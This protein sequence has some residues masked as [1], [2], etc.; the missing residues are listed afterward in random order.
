MLLVSF[1]FSNASYAQVGV[2]PQQCLEK[3]RA[4]TEEYPNACQFWMSNDPAA[5][6]LETT[7][8]DP[9]NG[10]PPITSSNSSVT[11]N[12]W[13]PFISGSVLNVKFA[14]DPLNPN[15]PRSLNVLCSWSENGAK[16][17]TLMDCRSAISFAFGF[18]GETCEVNPY[19]G[20][21][22]GSCALSVQE[23]GRLPGCTATDNGEYSAQH[24]C[25]T[26]IGNAI[27]N[28]AC[29]ARFQQ[30][31]ESMNLEGCE[32]RKELPKP[33][34]EMQQN[35]CK[36]F[37]D[38]TKDSLY[39]DYGRRVLCKGEMGVGNE[40]VSDNNYARAQTVLIRMCN[41]YEQVRKP[42]SPDIVDC[43]CQDEFT[44]TMAELWGSNS[45]T[46]DSACSAIVES[47]CRSSECW[48]SFKNDSVSAVLR[49]VL[50]GSGNASDVAQLLRGQQTA[51]GVSCERYVGP[52]STACKGPAGSCVTAGRIISPGS[53]TL[54]MCH[55]PEPVQIEYEDKQ[56]II[57]AKPLGR[58]ARKKTDVINPYLKMPEQAY[59]TAQCYGY[60]KEL[61]KESASLE[62]EFR[63]IMAEFKNCSRV[64]QI[65]NQSV[66]SCSIAR[67]SALMQLN[68]SLQ[69]L[70]GVDPDFCRRRHCQKS[71]DFAKCM[72]NLP[73][74][75]GV[76]FECVEDAIIYGSGCAGLVEHSTDYLDDT[77]AMGCPLSMRITAGDTPSLARNKITQCVDNV[78]RLN[79]HL[80][81]V[82]TV[83][84]REPISDDEYAVKYCQLIGLSE[85]IAESRSDEKYDLFKMS[86][87]KDRAALGG[88]SIYRYQC[89]AAQKKSRVEPLTSNGKTVL[90]ERI[91]E[92]EPSSATFESSLY[93]TPA[94]EANLEYALANMPPYPDMDMNRL[95]QEEG[96]ICRPIMEDMAEKPETRYNP[97]KEQNQN[98]TTLN[99]LGEKFSGDHS[100]GFSP[101][102]LED[103]KRGYT[104]GSDIIPQCFQCSGGAANKD[105][106]TL[107]QLMHWNRLP[108]KNCINCIKTCKLPNNR[109]CTCTASVQ[110]PDYQGQAGGNQPMQNYEGSSNQ[111][112]FIDKIETR[113]C[114]ISQEKCC[115]DGYVESCSGQVCSTEYMPT[116][117]QPV[118]NCCT[119]TGE[120]NCVE[121]VNHPWPS[122][123]ERCRW[124]KSDQDRFAAAPF[125]NTCPSSSP[126]ACCGDYL[127][128][129]IVP[130]N[131]LKLRAK[132]DSWGKEEYNFPQGQMSR[133][134]IN[135]NEGGSSRPPEGGPIN[136]ERNPDEDMK[137]ISPVP[138]GFY[139]E[140][141]FGYGGALFRGGLLNRQAPLYDHKVKPYMIWWDEGLP[142]CKGWND[143]IVGIGDENRNCGYGGW[144]EL[145]LYQ[146]R[147]L[148]EF[149]TN[150]M[151]NYERT[152]K[153]GSAE[154]YVHAASGTYVSPTS[155]T[156]VGSTPTAKANSQI[157]PIGWRG[158]VSEPDPEY[159]F[160]AFG[161]VEAYGAGN[162][163]AALRGNAAKY[164]NPEL[165]GI[166]RNMDG[167]K[168][169]VETGALRQGLE[170]AKE[171]D[172]LIW[173]RDVLWGSDCNKQTMTCSSFVKLAGKEPL[174]TPEARLPHVAHV[175]AAYTPASVLAHCEARKLLCKTAI[176]VGGNNRRIGDIQDN[177][178]FRGNRSPAANQDP[179]TFREQDLAECQ[180][181]N[182]FDFKTGNCSAYQPY[183][184]SLKSPEKWYV[185][186]SEKNY[187]K[188]PDI[189]GNTDKW[190]IVTSRTLIHP[191]ISADKLGLPKDIAKSE[192]SCS[193]PQIARC[194]EE[195]WDKVKVYNPRL[196]WRV[197]NTIRACREVANFSDD[198]ARL[199]A[200]RN[201]IFDAIYAGCDPIPALRQLGGSP[202]PVS[203]RNFGKATVDRT[204]E[205]TEP[206]TNDGP[207]KLAIMEFLSSDIIPPILEETRRPEDI[208]LPPE[209]ADGSII[210]T[211]LGLIPEISI[212]TRRGGDGS[213]GGGNGSGT[214]DND[215]DG[216]GSGGG[217]GSG[218]DGGG[219][220]NSNDNGL[221]G[222]NKSGWPACEMPQNLYVSNCSGCYV[223]T[224]RCGISGSGVFATRCTSTISTTKKAPSEFAAGD[225]YA[226]VKSQN[227]EDICVRGAGILAQPAMNS[228]SICSGGKCICLE[229]CQTTQRAVSA[230][231]ASGAKTDMKKFMSEI[232]QCVTRVPLTNDTEDKVYNWTDLK[233]GKFPSELKAPPSDF[234]DKNPKL[235]LPKCANPVPN[236]CL[237]PAIC[238][239]SIANENQQ[240]DFTGERTPCKTSLQ[241]DNGYDHDFVADFLYHYTNFCKVGA[242]KSDPAMC[243][244][245][246]NTPTIEWLFKP[247]I[248]NKLKDAD[249]K[250]MQGVS[251]MIFYKL[252]KTEYAAEE[253]SWQN[254]TIDELKQKM[255]LFKDI[256]AK[257]DVTK[258]PSAILPAP[259]IAIII[260]DRY[261]RGQSAIVYDYHQD[262]NCVDLISSNWLENSSCAAKTQQFD[263]HNC[264]QAIPTFKKGCIEYCVPLSRISFMFNPEAP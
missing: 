105:L 52:K 182:G 178:F 40:G 48:N 118:D 226:C 177:P 16:H 242:L 165:Y 263:A 191:S 65:N 172:I 82:R 31:L 100:D 260:S 92:P 120:G 26:N 51:G 3:G 62:K 76:N 46:I 68:S 12:C 27:S 25:R 72:E 88:G 49:P 59:R 28:S 84:K 135:T 250:E 252:T 47:G 139:F 257:Q 9:E 159:R 204:T 259:S 160:P 196:D 194:R 23:I 44:N 143:A 148:R 64:N 141:E 201:L 79:R 171:G 33:D 218:G 57:G 163:V 131:I 164:V 5:G 69:G 37:A 129:D 183:V 4:C 17:G 50:D 180:P 22:N 124:S 43:G 114:D 115:P 258:N 166:T 21:S 74:T 34:E 67:E 203:N 195:K 56:R 90:A 55:I 237:D 239:D 197:P 219:G 176:E 54:G 173:D 220:N 222:A 228:G 106:K 140:E 232:K 188:Y 251:G 128:D 117:P 264:Y 99:Q 256:V 217:D 130:H 210:S 38:A 208:P 78:I 213:G 13:E 155:F 156:Y 154:E 241:R 123:N 245:M 238:F 89:L 86:G 30:F 127:T 132:R 8:N 147:C 209:F 63:R 138:E 146:H 168:K 152:F 6:E 77:V 95:N 70:F 181:E 87:S 153:Y 169:L 187:G 97:K 236:Q 207:Q 61:W 227:G 229:S 104:E 75:A 73:Q 122:E 234:T 53:D 184:D 1:L 144:E 108:Y 247:E 170:N 151:C 121:D 243:R 35:W 193:D 244:A 211:G 125:C 235:G 186:V 36:S 111:P 94:N 212:W 175:R 246:T 192:G 149:S 137:R 174:K 19:A 66:S 145:K 199:L 255:V 18:N 81:V 224:G 133:A 162:S 216:N 230:D 39:R 58:H 42:S 109:T 233:Q 107:Y 158:Y 142:S 45:T 71:G 205:P 215:N 190:G 179:L 32:N 119:A 223:T 93:G 249:M 200:Q 198:P 7:L 10:N 102:H 101:R 240:C 157:W 231:A 167:L 261:Y 11:C 225:G 221:A 14:N 24:Q 253:S 96:S 185:I 29:P 150:C 103:F 262:R 248:A 60:V 2:P 134:R 80:P 15:N 110:N 214:G 113:V 206:G 83:T 91:L 98:F 161:M 136:V 116:E 41:G 126:E 112:E 20:N 85:D 202:K 189:C 254:P